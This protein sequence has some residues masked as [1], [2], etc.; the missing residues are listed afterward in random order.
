MARSLQRARRPSTPRLRWLG[1]PATAPPR[2]SR[3]RHLP[4]APLPRA[5]PPGRPSSRNDGCR[6]VPA[7]HLRAP[8]GPAPAPPHPLPRLALLSQGHP[9][10]VPGPHTPSRD[11]PALPGPPLPRARTSPASACPGVRVGPRL[12]QKPRVEPAQR[13][14]RAGPHL[15]RG[16]EAVLAPH[17]LSPGAPADGRSEPV[18]AWRHVHAC[19][20]HARQSGPQHAWPACAGSR[21]LPRRAHRS[22]A[23]RRSW[24]P[25]PR[26]PCRCS[27]AATHAWGP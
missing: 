18:V 13:A 14:C 8:R 19:P 9:L 26:R 22:R 27:R 3:P 25:L 1:G 6:A 5:S 15:R 24:P 10:P 4:G 11:A 12:C 21:G 7:E 16:R 23:E 2:A 20:S 17:A